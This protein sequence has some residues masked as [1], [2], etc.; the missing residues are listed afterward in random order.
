[1]ALA[2]VKA[3]APIDIS[4]RPKV[5]ARKKALKTLARWVHA[6]FISEQDAKRLARSKAEPLEVLK[7]ASAL[8]TA[9]AKTSDYS[10]VGNDDRTTA[11]TRDEVFNALRLA[12]SSK[13]GMQ[14]LIDRT[15]H[16]RRASTTRAAR[17]IAAVEER[18]AV[19]KEAIDKGVR[20]IPLKKLILRTIP[21]SEIRLA[22][23]YLNPLLKDSGALEGADKTVKSYEGVAYRQVPQ[24]VASVNPHAREVQAMLAWTAQTL[25]EGFAGK[26]L[27]DILSSKFSSTV[28][29]AGAKELKALRQ[30]HEGGSGFIYVNASAY[31][32]KTGTQGCENA[33]SKHRA[34]RVRFVL[35]M[36]R[37]ATCAKARKKADGTRVCG[38]YKK[39]IV[40]ASDLP[41]EIQEMRLANV[42]A[43]N[44]DDAESTAS[45]FAS[46]YDPGE[47]NLQGA[48]DR[49]IEFDVAPEGEDLADIVFG[50]M[51]F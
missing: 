15:V 21:A 13:K 51:E 19:I 48:L 34:N 3:P 33:A 36:D 42:K 47:F 10:G 27:T 6:G 18:V 32:S 43:A 20:G 31:A 9:Q 12:E 24:R 39:E 5:A 8:V 49:D 38:P 26:D 45:M 25:N 2:S 40:T 4:D 37:C 16:E 44:M 29:K 50:G 23:R 30:E 46:A 35:A 41:D 11:P 22:S 7:A 28:R 14:E 17:K 1:V